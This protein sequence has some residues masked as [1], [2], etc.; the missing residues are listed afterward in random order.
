M[1]LV[2][3]SQ[4][5]GAPVAGLLI[6]DSVVAIADVAPD[7]PT[8]VKAIIAG[9]DALAPKLAGAKGAIPL[10]DVKLHAPVDAPEKIMAIGLNYTDH[11]EESRA[12]G[13]KPPEAD[14]S[15]CVEAGPISASSSRTMM[16]S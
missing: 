8:D 6:G 11:I 16:S 2:R 9:W 10:A 7:A 12:A 4:G 14:C 1:K 13:V 15:Y 3:F 5:G